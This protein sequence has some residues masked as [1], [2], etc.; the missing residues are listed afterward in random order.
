M[1]VVMRHPDDRRRAVKAEQGAE[2]TGSRQAVLHAAEVQ[3]RRGV[4]ESQVE[5]RGKL[6]EQDADAGCG[7]HRIVEGAEPGG[8]P[9]R[10]DPEIPHHRE[11]R[12]QRR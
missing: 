12:I 1:V 11:Q 7:E 10:S 6:I 9:V 4:L 3:V 2:P 5:A 8:D